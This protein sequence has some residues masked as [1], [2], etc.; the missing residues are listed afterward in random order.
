MTHTKRL[1][2]LTVLC[3]M[4]CFGPTRGEKISDFT[5]DFFKIINKATG[6]YPLDAGIQEMDGGVIV[7]AYADM[8]SDSL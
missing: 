4:L 7:A 6:V 3:S 1:I 5:A 8:N 2:L